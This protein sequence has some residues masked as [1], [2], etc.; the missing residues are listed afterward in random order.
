MNVVGLTNLTS[1][2]DGTI[3]E[4]VVRNVSEI[5]GAKFCPGVGATENPNLQPPAAAK[6]QLLAGIFLAFMVLA[7]VLVAVFTDSL[8]RYAFSASILT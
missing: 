7:C 6:I 4:I 5:C 8:K 1:A 3:T 2:G